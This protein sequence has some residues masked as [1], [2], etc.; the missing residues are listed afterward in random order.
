MG[1]GSKGAYQGGPAPGAAAHAICTLWL[2]CTMGMGFVLWHCAQLCLD[3]L[4]GGIGG[5]ACALEGWALLL[6]MAWLLLLRRRRLTGAAPSGPHG[7]H[8]SAAPCCNQAAADG[9]QQE[10]SAR[11]ACTK[12]SSADGCTG[13]CREEKQRAK[14]Q[15]QRE[16]VR[17]QR[18]EA[19]LKSNE[20]MTDRQSFAPSEVGRCATLSCCGTG[21]CSYLPPWSSRLRT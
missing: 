19:A 5:V 3:Q 20:V 4:H 10:S 1:A 6:S 15:K 18:G 13:L 21:W 7:S 9:L 16:R 12:G 17:R 8:A 11:W 2:T 14:V